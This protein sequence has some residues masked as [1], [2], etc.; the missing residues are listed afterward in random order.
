VKAHHHFSDPEWDGEPLEPEPKTPK[1]VVEKPT[2][3]PYDKDSTD[4]PVRRQ[5][6]KVKLAD[7][8][9][10]TIQHMQVTSFW[11]P[12]GQRMSRRR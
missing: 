5:R 2:G 12:D 1:A 4:T 9:D 6:V 3:P 10:R 8:K 7:G 11:H